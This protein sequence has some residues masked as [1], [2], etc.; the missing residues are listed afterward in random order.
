MREDSQATRRNRF[1][2]PTKTRQPDSLTI[3]RINDLLTDNLIEF[4]GTPSM[5]R[6]ITEAITL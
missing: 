5:A 1:D 6:Q 3:L 4:P 2:V